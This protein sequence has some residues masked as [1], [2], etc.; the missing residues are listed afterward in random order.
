VTGVTIDNSS[1]ACARFVAEE[2]GLIRACGSSG[3]GVAF[4][5][6]LV[7]FPSK[8]R[9]RPCIYKLFAITSTR[10]GHRPRAEERRASSGRGISTRRGR[11]AGVAVATWQFLHWMRSSLCLAEATSTDESY[12]DRSRRRARQVSSDA[13]DRLLMAA[14]RVSRLLTALGRRFCA[15]GEEEKLARR[16]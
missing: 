3:P 9:T 4:I 14:A 15:S 7:D 1:A 13:L 6:M 2:A 16:S 10:R 11:L 5:V 8:R 12:R